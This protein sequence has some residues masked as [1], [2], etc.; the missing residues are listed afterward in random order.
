MMVGEVIRKRTRLKLP[1][2]SDGTI[3]GT[4]AL[5]YQFSALNDDPADNLRLI[6]SLKIDDQDQAVADC[7]I[8][9]RNSATTNYSKG[10]VLYY[11]PKII[12]TPPSW[13]AKSDHVASEGSHEFYL[14]WELK[15]K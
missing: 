9:W 10:A 4:I 6:A 14:P 11:N 15:G 3:A 8:A 12:K 13:V 5:R 1:Y 2:L 7:I